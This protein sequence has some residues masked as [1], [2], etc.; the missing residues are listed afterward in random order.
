MAKRFVM[1][2]IWRV[3][4]SYTLL[5]LILWGIVI[6]LTANPIVLPFMQHNFGID[7]TATGVVA[8]SLL[9]VFLGVFGIL[10]LFGIIYDK[11]LHLWRD[12]LDVA[13]DRNPYAREKLMV[14]EI[15]MWRHMFLPAM[16]T[17]PDPRT[18][19]EI[20]FMERWIEKSLASDVNIRKSVEDAERWI[21]T[22]DSPRM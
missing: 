1:T 20:A 6:A 18:Q 8:A 4:Q 10:F 14:K 19:K 12:Q 3:Q 5:S 11:Y 22:G 17:S 7:P 15:L 16:R 2:Q 13:Y 21:A 9:L